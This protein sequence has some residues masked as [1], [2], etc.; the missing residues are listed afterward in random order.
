MAPIQFSEVAANSSGVCIVAPEQARPLVAS[1]ISLSPAALAVVTVGEVDVRDGK[2]L[3]WPA[4]HVPTKE[5]GFGK[6]DV[7]QLA[8]VPD[9]PALPTIST[10]V[11]RVTV[12]RDFFD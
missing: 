10:E 9:A 8:T 3:Q 5:P 7:D 6:R 2:D 4:F 1:E 11:V 12:F